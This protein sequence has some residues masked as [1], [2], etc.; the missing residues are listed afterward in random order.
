[1]ETKPIP[2][3]ARDIDQLP[4]CALIGTAALMTLSGYSRTTIWRK[5]KNGTLP[6]ARKIGGTHNR[7]C[8]GDIR[9]L[10]AGE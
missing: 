5:E 1:M 8:V 10:L 3:G 2:A 6:K 7:W 9:A 4:D